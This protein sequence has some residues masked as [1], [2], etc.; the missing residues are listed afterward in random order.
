V[1]KSAGIGLLDYPCRAGREV[2]QRRAMGF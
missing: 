2:L 1:I